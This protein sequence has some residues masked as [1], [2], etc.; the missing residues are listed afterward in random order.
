[1]FGPR[2]VS[3]GPAVALDGPDRQQHHTHYARNALIYVT[4]SKSALPETV[5][6][7]STDVRMF[8]SLQ[9]IRV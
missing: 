1:M 7:F 8:A 9:I 2:D 5:Y 6:S 3:A 4:D